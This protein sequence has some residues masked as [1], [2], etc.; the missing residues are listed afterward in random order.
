MG[1]IIRILDEEGLDVENCCTAMGSTAEIRDAWSRSAHVSRRCLQGRVTPGARCLPK[2]TGP[3]SLV[4]RDHTANASFPWEQANWQW[5]HQALLTVK[6][7]LHTYK[8]EEWQAAAGA[9][10]WVRR[11]ASRQPPRNAPW[12]HFV[13]GGGKEGEGVWDHALEIPSL[14]WA[15]AFSFQS[16]W[17]PGETEGIKAGSQPFVCSS[18]VLGFFSFCQT[19]NGVLASCKM[20]VMLVWVVITIYGAERQLLFNELS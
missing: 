12:C 1:N 15:H 6:H 19:D 7:L 14:P 8:S 13:W 10:A 3:I 5:Q 9:D 17:E 16:L 20:L 18:C 11:C 2:V 4:G